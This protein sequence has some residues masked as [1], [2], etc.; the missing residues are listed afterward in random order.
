M[1]TEILFREYDMVFIVAWRRRHWPRQALRDET[2]REAALLPMHELPA[3][4]HAKFDQRTIDALHAKFG[5]VDDV[6]RGLE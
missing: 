3:N 4:P 1:A 2:G 5:H 6:F